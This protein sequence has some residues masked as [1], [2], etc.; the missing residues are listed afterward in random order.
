MMVQ[1]CFI[2]LACVKTA[3]TYLR[4]YVTQLCMQRPRNPAYP[5]YSPP[6]LVSGRP[7]LNVL[8]SLGVARV[9]HPARARR[10][11]RV[12]DHVRDPVPGVGPPNLEPG[13]AA[14]VLFPGAFVL[15]DGVPPDVH[16]AEQLDGVP[17]VF[18]G[19]DPLAEF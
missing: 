7:I 8:P 19:E 14:L 4:K 12:D 13:P 10:L 17:V 18:E 16:R 11:D 3:A 15:L 5:S 2:H 6:R 1:P 9:A